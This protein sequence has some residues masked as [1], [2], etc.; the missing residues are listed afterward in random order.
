MLD[1]FLNTITIIAW[2]IFALVLLYYGIRG[3]QEGGLRGIIKNIFSGQVMVILLIALAVTLFS[4]ALIF[5]E[6]QEVGVVVSLLNRDGYRDQPFRSGLHWVAP[7]MEKVSRYPIY[8]QTYT[9]SSAPLEGE[10]VGDDSIAA[11]T[12]D[13]QAVFL[14]VSVIYRIDSNDVIRI[15]IDLQDRYVMDF[16]R[17]VLRGI[18]RTEVSQF[19][20][21]E[22]NSSKRKNLELILDEKIRAA[23]ADKGFILDR[24]LLRNIGFSEEYASAIE[25]KQVAEQ[26]KVQREFEAEQIRKLAEGQRDKFKLE[27]AGKADAV[28]LEGEAEAEVIL[29]KAQAEADALKL[30]NEAIAQNENLITYRYIDKLG[31]GVQVML[32][33]S[34][35]PFLLPLPDITSGINTSPL[36]ELPEGLEA[37]STITNTQTITPTNELLVTPTPTT[38]P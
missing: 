37:T 33:P 29:I 1:Q 28:I 31:P 15:H 30:I 7:L 3:F 20:A 23:F 9:M 11:R 34:D 27:A 32:V 38:V 16:I 6:P 13:G 4:A 36:S 21:D 5:I 22:V 10:K 2:G 8:W 12:S 35:N 18:V 17:P 24:F 19:T 14:D 26:Q 25:N